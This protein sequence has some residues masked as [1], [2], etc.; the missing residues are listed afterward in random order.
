MKQPRLHMLNFILQ[1][2]WF[3]SNMLYLQPDERSEYKQI[4]KT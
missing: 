4:L 3:L 1:F 2:S